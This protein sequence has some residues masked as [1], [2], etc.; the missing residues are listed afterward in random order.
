MPNRPV[1]RTTSRVTH[2][3]MRAANG[4]PVPRPPSV[5][6]LDRLNGGGR[7][8]HNVVLLA[9]TVLPGIDE[10]PEDLAER[11]RQHVNGTWLHRYGTA[12]QVTALGAWPAPEGWDEPQY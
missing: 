9:V 6:A 1:R 8:A 2:E 3:Q 12:H 11:M 4:V 5:E 10:D 7:S